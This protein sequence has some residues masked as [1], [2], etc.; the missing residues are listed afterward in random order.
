M[1]KNLFRIC[2]IALLSC[3]VMFAACSKDDDDNNEKGVDTPENSG[4]GST[5]KIAVAGL[6][7]SNIVFMMDADT[8]VSVRFDGGFMNGSDV[9]GYK[10]GY[11]Q[12]VADTTY[13]V[14][15]G[16]YKMKDADNLEFPRVTIQM[17]SYPAEND[18]VSV[19]VLVARYIEYTSDTTYT[20]WEKTTTDWDNSELTYV[21]AD[22][23]SMGCVL[24]FN[25][26]NAADN[27]VTA[28]M[29][30]AIAGKFKFEDKTSR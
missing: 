3:A 7:A 20:I 27:S 23:L 17:Y 1:K 4:G 19:G 25:M 8:S 30:F 13:W 24:S 29:R 15:D 26:A 22:D 10:A 2:G 21:D 28:A 6:N 14:F 5:A 11:V 12:K 9:L 16:A 18:Q